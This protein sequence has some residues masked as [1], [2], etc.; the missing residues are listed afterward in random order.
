MLIMILGAL[1]G[2]IFSLVLPQVV[3]HIRL[4][5]RPAFAGE[6]LSTWEPK[7]AGRPS[8][9]NEKMRVT[10][11]FGRLRF[12]N[13]EN[14]CSYSYEGTARLIKNRHLVGTWRSLKPGA[15]SSGAFLLT[16]APQGHYLFGQIVGPNDEGVM[17]AGRYVLGRSPQDVEEGKRMLD[18]EGASGE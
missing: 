15:Y 4:K 17:E 18:R 3:D 9:V 14:E 7:S 6:W 11:E 13:S 12:S 2:A 10:I 16:V 5:K 1:L 8:W